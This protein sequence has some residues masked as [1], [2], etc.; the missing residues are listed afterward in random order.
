MRRLLALIQS[1]SL[2]F[3]WVQ[4]YLER[5]SP[6]DPMDPAG[7]GQE[8]WVS[9][10]NYKWLLDPQRIYWNQD[11]SRSFTCERSR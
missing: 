5:G 4:P 7:N 1:D 11:D 8:K 6:N 2:A 9:Q 10:A 3:W